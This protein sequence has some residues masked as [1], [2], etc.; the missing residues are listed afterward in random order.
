MRLFGIVSGMLNRLHG[1]PDS[2]DKKCDSPRLLS[3]SGTDTR[4]RS[5]YRFGRTLGAGTYRVDILINSQVVGSA[6][7]QLK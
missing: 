5:R 1:Q 7:F 2:Y 4:T 6:T 3:A